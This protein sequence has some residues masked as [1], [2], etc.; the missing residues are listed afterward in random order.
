MQG[1]TLGIDGRLPTNTHGGLL[2]EGYIHGLN[3]L[4]EAVRL[5]RGTSVNQPKKNTENML[6]S[7][8]AG[9]PTSALIIGKCNL[10]VKERSTAV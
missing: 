6:V 7:S 8:G 10:I 5:M 2:S 1:G 3:G 4:C 9:M